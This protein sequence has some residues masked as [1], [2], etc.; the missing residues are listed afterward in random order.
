MLIICIRKSQIAIEY[1]Y[2]IQSN[3]P[4]TW[5]FWVDAENITK[6]EESYREIAK[7]LHISGAS[8]KD[9]DMFTLVFDWLRNE[10]N[11]TWVMII[12][13][14][15]DKEVFMSRPPNYRGSDQSKQI[16]EFIPQ[17]SNG[18]IL[19]TSRSRDAAFQVTCNYKNIQ[20]V[21]PM[22]ESEALT[23]LRTQLEG[24]H[25]DENMR[26]LVETLDYIPLAITHAAAHISRR[27][28]PIR[29]YLQELQT[30]DE[31]SGSL[32][33]ED[34]A[35]LRRTTGRSGSVIATWRI[36]FEYVRKTMPSAARLLS[37]M[38]LFDRQDIPEAL[39]Q[40]QYG[41]EVA[42]AGGNRGNHGYEEEN[43]NN[44]C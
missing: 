12:D 39:L 8:E 20:T 32:L 11:A 16:R 15:D 43:N 19:V 5:I 14:A 18:S 4:S 3:S 13:N 40:G 6:L 37:L 29:D 25:E 2:R 9:V 35:Q 41:E 22:N 38:C 23:L 30:G 42:N 26:T 10:A 36:T 1:G 27:S 28:L 7:V 24:E 17:S 44:F 31:L 34:I 33:D 21:E